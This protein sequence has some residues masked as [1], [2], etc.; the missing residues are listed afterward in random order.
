V[1]NR[2]IAWLAIAALSA[3]SLGLGTPEAPPDLTGRWQLNEK[4][5]EDA[6]AKVGWGGEGA[7]RRPGERPA[8]PGERRPE[9]RGPGGRNL[10]DWGSPPTTPRTSVTGS[11]PPEFGDFLEPA[12]ALVITGTTS[13]LTLDEGRGVLVRLP[14]DGSAQKE[15]RLTR[16]ARWDGETLVV[17]SRVESAGKLTTRYSL[18]PG[19]RRLEVYSRLAAPQGGAITIRRVYDP[20]EAS[21]SSE[22]A[23]S[24]LPPAPSPRRPASQGSAPQAPSPPSPLPQEDAAE[25]PAPRAERP[26]PA[27]A[28]AGKEDVPSFG[29]TTELVYVRFHVERKGEYVDH[30]SAD[31]IRVLEDG[32]PQTVALLETPSTRERTLAPEITLALDVSSSVMDAGL[33]DERLIRDVFLAGL[34][35][36]TS[37]GLC[38][39]GGELRCFVEPTQNAQ[40]LLHGFQDAL[41]FGQASRGQG[42]RLYASLA[43]LCHEEAVRPPAP[44]ALVVFSDGLDNHGGS[45]KEAINGALAS[46]VRVYAV[47]LSQA[48]QET[49]PLR[50]GGFGR[51]PARAMYDYRKLDLNRLAGETGGRAYEPATV[52]KRVIAEILRD[53]ATEISMEHVVGYQPQGAATGRKRRVKVE[54]AD[55]SIGRIPDGERTLLR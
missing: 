39:F 42:T 52:D 55:K 36:D 28:T 35:R 10:G 15:D 33:L 13:E 34:S 50:A 3:P 25:D 24:E 23:A 32:R 22:S 14:L 26:R 5:S 51:P 53:I 41:F 17:E 49:A 6:R 43:E 44:R 47:K 7:P 8:Y 38:A 9:E 31:Q 19:S 16:V 29:V 46:D 37:V 27:A 18:M 12:K 4:E 2:R 45:V 20:A 1:I 21:E 48:F 54:L 40:Q 30:L 11:L